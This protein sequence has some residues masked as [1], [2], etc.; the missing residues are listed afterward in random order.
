MT[1]VVNLDFL[2]EVTKGKVKKKME[3]IPGGEIILGIPR[4]DETVDILLVDAE[5][6]PID[7][8]IGKVTKKEI[9]IDTPTEL[10]QKIYDEK[11]AETKEKAAEQ[12]PYEEKY[13]H[14]KAWA[15]SLKR[16][17][18]PI[19]KVL[20]VGCFR[21]EF[22]RGFIE[23]GIDAYGVDVSKDAIA[24]GLNRAPFLKE[25]LIVCDVDK[26]TIP[27]NDEYF[28]LIIT[29][30]TIEHLCSPPKCI[31]EM[32]RVLK[33][34]GYIIVVTHIPGS[35]HDLS[36]KTHINVRSEKEWVRLF[37][38]HGLL[39][40]EKLERELKSKL[41]ELKPPSTEKGVALVKAGKDEE[42]KERVRKMLEEDRVTLIFYKEK[43]S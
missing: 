15:V 21:G 7:K 35:D 24:K 19:E 34:G 20:D 10:K 17:F 23:L 36:D 37:E 42:R 8:I 31:D 38:K 28:D 33:S 14:Y 40:D 18:S 2:D 6:N 26:E 32:R 29:I 5:G 16:V 3:E 22:V 30:N 27:F 25:K 13:N 12:L 11:Y 41:I 39:R 1:M 4:E 9:K 43:R